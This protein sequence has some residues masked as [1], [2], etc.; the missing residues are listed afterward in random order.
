VRI[1]AVLDE[2]LLKMRTR[3]PIFP[4]CNGGKLNPKSKTFAERFVPEGVQENYGPSGGG[5]PDG[6]CRPLTLAVLESE[7]KVA[8]MLAAQTGEESSAKL[9][10]DC[11]VRDPAIAFR[12]VNPETAVHGISVSDNF[13]TK[14]TL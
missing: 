11:A 9:M 14:I 12:A 6:P 8:S 13:V 5:L 2:P 10:A 7:R 4:V 1:S 3:A